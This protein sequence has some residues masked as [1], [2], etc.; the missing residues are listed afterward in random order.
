MKR[1]GI[2]EILFAAVGLF[3]LNKF[4]ADPQWYMYPVVFAISSLFAY[5]LKS[6]IERYYGWER[7]KS[8][9]K[10]LINGI[11]KDVS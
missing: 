6:L 5:L 2:T 4:S 3:L 9:F 1:V 10:K 7:F 8:P 11:F